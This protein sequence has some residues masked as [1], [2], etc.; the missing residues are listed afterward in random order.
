MARLSARHRLRQTELEAV[1]S[2]K[3]CIHD[4][5]VSNCHTTIKILRIGR[6]QSFAPT[7]RLVNRL[8][9]CV[10]PPMHAGFFAPLSPHQVQ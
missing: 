7:D 10:F 8:G 6:C 2:P 9:P 5:I 3:P 4:D 1:Q